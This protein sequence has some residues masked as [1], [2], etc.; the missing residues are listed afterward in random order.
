MVSVTLRDLLSMQ[1]GIRSRDYHVYGYEVWFNM[2][3]TDDWVY[4][5]IEIDIGTIAAYG[6]WH[7]PDM[8]EVFYQWV[9]YSDPDHLIFTLTQN[10]IEVAETSVTSSTTF[11][12]QYQ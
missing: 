7:F 1:T 11:M 2:Q 4:R 6:N 8:F 3:A 10:S 9:G 12:G 5:H